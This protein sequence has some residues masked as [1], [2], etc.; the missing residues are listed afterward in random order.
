MLKGQSEETT[1]LISTKYSFG[2]LNWNLFCEFN[3]S[4]YRSN[5]LREQGGVIV[6]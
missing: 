3:F 1:K 4:S 5:I 6:S 2:S